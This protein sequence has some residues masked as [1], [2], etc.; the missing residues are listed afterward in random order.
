MIPVEERD[1]RILIWLHFF[2]MAWDK[3][4]HQVL[5]HTVTAI[6][7]DEDFNEIAAV[8]VADSPLDDVGFFVD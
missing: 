5:G 7:F 6:A 8:M 3:K 4:L 2:G 1:D